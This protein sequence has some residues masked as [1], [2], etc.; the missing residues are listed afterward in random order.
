MYVCLFANNFIF[1][2]QHDA[3]PKLL[4]GIC[5]LSS[6]WMFLY[7]NPFRWVQLDKLGALGININA[8]MFLGNELV[9]ILMFINIGISIDLNL[10]IIFNNNRSLALVL[11]C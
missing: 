7:R 10:S 1:F 8:V 2:R 5:F 11:A 3:G 4:A 6:L 9:M